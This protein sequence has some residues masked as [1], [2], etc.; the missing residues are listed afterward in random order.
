MAC[1]LSGDAKREGSRVTVRLARHSKDFSKR[2]GKKGI[3]A[4]CQ[5][6]CRQGECEGDSDSQARLLAVGQT[7]RSLVVPG[8]AK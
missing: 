7:P 1:R 8:V 5:L 2:T 4:S 3:V 6:P